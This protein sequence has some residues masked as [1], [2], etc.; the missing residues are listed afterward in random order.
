MKGHGEKIS[1][2]QEKAIAALLSCSTIS[3]AAESIGIG[4]VTLHRWLKLEHFQAA[5]RGARR[6]VVNQAIALVQ[7]GMSDAV[8]TLRN[9]MTNPESPASSR[10]S[11][12]KAMLDIG[13]KAFEVEDLAERVAALEKQTKHIN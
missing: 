11:A 4:E 2:N 3:D 5:Y 10:V 6:Q 8:A 9:V 7:A 1:R 13:V 12:A